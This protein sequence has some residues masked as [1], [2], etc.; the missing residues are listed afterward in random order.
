M[1]IGVPTETK[2]NEF[3]VSISPSGVKELVRHGHQVIVQAGA[4]EGAGF[5]DEDYTAAGALIVFSAEEIFSRAE[6][7]VKVKEPIPVECEMLKEN[8]ILFCYLHLAAAPRIA[9]MLIDSNC[10]AIGYETVTDDQG[11]LPL[12]APMS[13]VA[14][15]MAV[16]AGAYCLEKAQGGAGML[17]SGVPGVPPSRVV[18]LGGGVVGTNAA[19]I[20]YGMGAEVIVL[21]KSIKRIREIDH[22]FR[23]GVKTV[24]STAGLMEEYIES[25]DVV[26]GAV[27]VPGAAAPKLIKAATVK[28]M[29]RGAVIVDVAIDQGGC[30]ET[31]K[32]TTHDDPVYIVDGVVHYCVSNIPGAVPR[33]AT[34][35]LENSTLPYIIA[36]ADK[37]YRAA[38]REDI[39]FRN[40]LIVHRGRITHEVVARELNHAYVPPATFLN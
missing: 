5:T 30:A 17:L 14:G 12:L 35:G 25:A 28:N 22:M 21:E 18:V 40:G 15:R 19:Q 3:R 29:K 24:Y 38:L 26:I 10:I 33:T 37:G 27:L 6:M 4:G 13:E 34:R 2:N 8:Q 36:L 16:Q 31:S 9:E 20:A 7:V 11:G 32:P 39:H 23:G 1:L